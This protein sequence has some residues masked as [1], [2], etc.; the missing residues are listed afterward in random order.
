MN[1]A[2][3]K[4]ILDRLDTP[5]RYYIAGPMTGYREHNYPAFQHATDTLRRAGLDVISPHELHDGDTEKPWAW[6]LRRDIIA[7]TS[8]THIVLLPGWEH[9]EGATF[10]VSIAD[11]L[12]IRRHH[13]ADLAAQLRH[14]RRRPYTRLRIPHVTGGHR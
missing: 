4:N 7:L 14:G 10:E 1:D 12:G 5:T 8:C 6:Y 3:L 2:K 9:S 13:F 11:K